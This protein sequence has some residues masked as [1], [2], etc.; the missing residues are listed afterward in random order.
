VRS[1]RVV[2]MFVIGEPPVDW[3]DVVPVDPDDIPAEALAAEEEDGDELDGLGP[4]ELWALAEADDEE[5]R[6]WVNQQVDELDA[7]GVLAAAAEAQVTVNLAQARQLFLAVHW[8]DLHATLDRPDRP[9]GGGR[10]AERLV[11]LGGEGTPEV[12]EFAAAELGVVLGLSVVSA[13]L[14]IGDALDLRHR[15]PRLWHRLQTGSIKIWVVRRI[16]TRTRH[17]TITAA[18]R[19]DD[20]LCEVAGR[21]VGGRLEKILEGVSDSLCKASVHARGT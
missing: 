16:A 20:R 7:D 9:D 17:L 6:R 14:L 4:V 21:V 5:Q 12:G 8:A 11:R 13:R 2:S 1:S 3:V 18:G 10:G 19:V 15:L